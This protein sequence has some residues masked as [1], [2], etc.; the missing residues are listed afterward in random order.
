MNLAIHSTVSFPVATLRRCR[1]GFSL[2]ELL[3]VIGV[4]ALLVSILLPA[5]AQARRAANKAACLS[6]LRQVHQSFHLY[7]LD[8]RDIVPLGHRSVTKQFNSMIY[9]ITASSPRWVLFGLL[10]E[11]GHIA[12]PRVLYCPAETNLA[13]MYNTPANPWPQEGLPP[14]ANIQ[15][16]Y[17]ARPEYRIE[18]DLSGRMPRLNDLKN[19]AIFADL[20]AARVRV[21]TR[22]GDGINVLYG[23]GGAQWVSLSV[24][25][26]PANQWA[27]PTFPLNDMANPIHDTIWESLDQF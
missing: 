12:D 1:L 17:G 19:R 7:A 10:V 27:E 13:F 4:I 18:D 16:G 15:S 20:T 25:D 8:H 14:S 6:N 9:S 24:F 11:S 23:H 3:V 2:V 26:Q 5:L 22:H 21:I